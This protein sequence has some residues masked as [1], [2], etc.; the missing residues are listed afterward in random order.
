MAN[1][2]GVQ[3]HRVIKLDL[4]AI[5]GSALTDEIEHAGRSQDEMAAG[6]PIT[7]VPAEQVL[8]ALALGYAETPGAFDLFLG[9]N[10]LDYSGYPDCRPEFLRQFEQLANVATKAGVKGPRPLSHPTAHCST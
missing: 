7:Y 9:V 8:L 5:G 6:I 10:A 3:E 4:R 2:L 1:A